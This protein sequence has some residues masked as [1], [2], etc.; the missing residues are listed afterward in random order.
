MTL[1]C[2]TIAQL[3]FV[4][5]VLYGG[6][7]SFLLR[8]YLW[9]LLIFSGFWR[10]LARFAELTLLYLFKLRRWEFC[11]CFSSARLS[12]HTLSC[13]TVA[14][15]LLPLFQ[16]VLLCCDVGTPHADCA[17][18]DDCGFFSRWRV[19]RVLLLFRGFFTLRAGGRLNPVIIIF[20]IRTLTYIN[21]YFYNM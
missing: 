18:G 21:E 12:Y 3:L 15:L 16:W 5:L 1:F 10:H 7:F 20:S 17:V 19:S 8:A 14:L 13:D 9:Y 6:L 11:G 2:M 4:G